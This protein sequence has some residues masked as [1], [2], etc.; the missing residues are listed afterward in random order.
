MK[1][2]YSQP[3]LMS[4]SYFEQIDLLSA[5]LVYAEV[6]SGG[7]YNFASGRTVSY[8]LISSARFL[9]DL[10]EITVIIKK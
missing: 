1:G 2:D 4:G 5:Y 10:A 7:R 6:V 8:R 3:G 9:H